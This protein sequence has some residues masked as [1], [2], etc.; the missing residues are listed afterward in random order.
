[1]KLI[2]IIILMIATAMITHYMVLVNMEIKID[3]QSK[4][5]ML[6][7]IESYGQEHVYYLEK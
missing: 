4:S 1:M 6:L 2:K 7:K 3:Q 5:G